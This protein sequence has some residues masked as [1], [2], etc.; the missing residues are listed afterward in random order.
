M[1]TEK[2]GEPPRGSR[3]LE[4]PKVF[5]GFSDTQGNYSTQRY[6]GTQRCSEDFQCSEVLRPLKVLVI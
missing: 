5:R 6:Q 4:T 3:Y 1:A 2:S